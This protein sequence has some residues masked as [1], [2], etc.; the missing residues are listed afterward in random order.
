MD[1]DESKDEK[2]MTK[3]SNP[4]GK[5]SSEQS[6]KPP[7]KKKSNTGH[8]KTSSP[9]KRSTTTVNPQMKSP[10]KSNVQPGEAGKVT[11]PFGNLSFD[12]YKKV[13]ESSGSP[14]HSLVKDKEFVPI[15]LSLHKEPTDQSREEDKK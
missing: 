12:Q 15:K 9:K 5:E 14:L 11:K 4:T 6:A 2:D 13:V 3:E 1:N 7:K 10:K 8:F